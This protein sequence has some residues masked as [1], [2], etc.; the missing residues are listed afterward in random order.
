[1]VPAPRSSPD[2]GHGLADATVAITSG[3]P[4]RSPDAPLNEAV[5]FASTFHAGGPVAYG[6]DGNPTW[7]AFEEALGALEGGTAL[8]FASGMAATAAV[9]EEVPVGGVLVVPR[10]SYYGTRNLVSGAPS[11]RWVVRMVDIA[12]TEAVVD[13][14][15][16]AD[17]LFIESPGNP[18]L[19]VADVPRLCV[20]AHGLGALVVVDNTF[21]TPLGQRPLDLGADVVVHSVSKFLAGHADVVLGA[22]VVGSHNV[23]LSE[24]LRRR[25]SSNGSIPGPMEVFLALRGLRTLALRFERAQR[26]ANEL[27]QRLHDHQGVERVRYPGLPG[28]P[29]HKRA[30]A[31]MRAPG[32]VVSFEVFGG[33]AVAEA[34]ARAT[35]LIVH[36]TSLGGIETTIERRGRWPGE[37]ETP[38]ALLRMSV[39]CED[40]EDLWADLDH[41]LGIGA[42]AA[43]P[44]A[45]PVTLRGIER[46]RPAPGELPRCPIARY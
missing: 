22:T 23:D 40:L 30:T 44:G 37:E 13:A 32:F 34:V 14:C 29:W 2:A 25:R 36:A 6:R 45:S 18:M 1:V 3:R 42:R 17:L 39:G 21:A 4:R 19:E 8:A 12:D 11:G 5:T 43:V 15:D 38:P 16:G 28:D 9:L 31:N 20:E 35:R 7:S 10:H 26:N 24:R 46:P 33:A 41:A 27:A